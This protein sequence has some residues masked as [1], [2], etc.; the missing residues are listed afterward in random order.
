MIN[1]KYGVVYTP[2][3]LAAFVASLLIDC[4]NE[5]DHKVENILDPAC[6]E[7][8]LLKAYKALDE[9]NKV[10]WGIDVDEMV[11]NKTTN[12]YN[13]CISDAILPKTKKTTKEYWQNKMPSIQAVIANPPWSSEKIYDRTAL[14]N[15]G[16]RLVDGQYDS[17]V[18]FLEFAYNILQ[19]D[20]F[21]AFIIHD[22]LFDAQ[23]ES[24]RR[25]LTENT[26]IKIIARLGEKL[27]NGVNRA[28]TVLIC[29]KRKPEDDSK[30][31]CFRLSTNNRKS[32]LLGKKPLR[33]YFDK[34][35]HQVLQKRFMLNPS[36]NYD[37]DTREEEED[38]LLI[39]LSKSSSSSRVSTS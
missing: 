4:I 10:F 17:Y 25:F 23:N 32:Y 9:S 26:Q 36:C 39:L 34:Y 33:F 2:D 19:E 8:A 22:S 1:M 24:L 35:S 37:V 15:A 12:G 6:G 21:F 27:F 7:G 29:Q 18:L 38:S 3:S 14:R 5:A 31:T 13:I 11:K 16:Y 28:T 30:T 20:G